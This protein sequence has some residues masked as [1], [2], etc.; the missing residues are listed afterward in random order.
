MTRQKVTDPVLLAQLNAVES[1]RQKVTDPNLLAQLNADEKQPEQTEQDNYFNLPRDMILGLARLANKPYQTGQMLESQFG[2]SKNMLDDLIAQKFPSLKSVTKTNS[3]DNFQ[4]DV[5]KLSQ[6]LGQNAEGTLLDQILQAGIEHAP[7]IYAGGQLAKSGIK[8]LIN[9]GKKGYERFALPKT[10]LAESEANLNALK[11]AKAARMGNFS[12]N[13]NDLMRNFRENQEAMTQRES[14][15]NQNL[16]REFPIK[17]KQETLE[18]LSNESVNT[19][20]AL[21]NEFNERYSSFRNSK[22]AQEPVKDPI[23]IEDFNKKTEGLTGLSKTTQTAGKNIS[24]TDYEYQDIHGM[25]HKIET[26][27]K[28]ATVNDY[29]EYSKQLRDAA[30]NAKSAA[31]DLPYLEK[32]AYNQTANRLSQ[33]QKEVENKIVNTIGEEA[34]AP[35][36]QINADYSA[37]MG[38]IRSNPTLGKAAYGGEVSNNIFSKLLQKENAGLREHLFN[39]PDYVRALREHLIQ[40]T[41]H[42]LRR[43]AARNEAAED[44]DIQRLLTD[45]QKAVLEEQKAIKA[46]NENLQQASKN[47]KEPDLLTAAEDYQLRNFSPKANAFLNRIAHEKAI[48]AQMEDEAKTLGITIE[49]LQ[50]EWRNRKIIGGIAAG[51]LAYKSGLPLSALFHKVTGL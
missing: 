26:P 31:A 38:S 7:E 36:K 30:Y 10:Q 46:S 16:I 9:L 25:T 43:G 11:E 29:I 4:I 41:K 20:K 39:N 44:L 5:P 19:R 1:P 28:N 14:E 42:P 51:V 21:E 13:K 2:Q 3:A 15:N 6:S 32:Q 12:Q 45:K 17:S 22:P 18:N 23:N 33:L 48:T 40:G 47:I 37:K 35:Y 49:Q 50:K 24:K 27:P 34:Y 8:G